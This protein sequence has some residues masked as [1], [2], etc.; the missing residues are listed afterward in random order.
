MEIKIK[1]SNPFGPTN[2]QEIKKMGEETYAEWPDDYKQFMLKHN[3]GTPQTDIFKYKR[4][5]KESIYPVSHF[6]GIH[7]GEYWARMQ[8]A[9]ESLQD[10][11][12][13]EFLP[14]AYDG[15]GNHYLINL[16]K[17]KY[18]KIYYWDHE[19]EAAN[20]GVKYYRNIKLLAKSFTDFI[21]NLTEDNDDDFE[22]TTRIE[23]GSFII[24]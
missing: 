7:D 21:A 16:S 4:G 3:G 10:R 2:S 23:G 12:P 8:W 9:L 18:G 5:S 6:F 15:G 1:D 19:R 13:P 11:M 24:E 17:E 22:V 20:S 14:I